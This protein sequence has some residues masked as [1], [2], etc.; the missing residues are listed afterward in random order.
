M[1]KQMETELKVGDTV[2]VFYCGSPLC[3]NRAAKDQLGGSGCRGTV[4]SIGRR[5]VHVSSRGNPIKCDGIVYEAVPIDQAK[6]KYRDMLIA[7][8][9]GHRTA[10]QIEQYVGGL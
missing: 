2:V 7:N 5:N 1:S 9:N 4:T 10:E 6:I 3:H 8:P